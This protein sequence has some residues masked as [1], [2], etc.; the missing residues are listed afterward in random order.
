MINVCSPYKF[1]DIQMI[2]IMK[3]M[4]K[5]KFITIKGSQGK[6][7]GKAFDKKMCLGCQ[8]N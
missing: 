1:V 6:L 3:L 5:V 7:G 2:E 8:D 4:E